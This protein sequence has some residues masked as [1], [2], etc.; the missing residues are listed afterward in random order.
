MDED[1]PLPSSGLD[2]DYF[3][4]RRTWVDRLS[5]LLRRNVFR[6]PFKAAN[7]EVVPRILAADR[8]GLRGVI[9]MG[10]ASLCGFLKDRRYRNAYERPRVEGIEVAP[11]ERRL[12]V[13][14]LLFGDEWRSYYFAAV[15]LGGLGCRFYGEFCVVLRSERTRQ[16]S[17]FDRNSYDLL[18]PPLDA[19]QD[20][21]SVVRALR[22]L[23]DRDVIPMLTA[24]VVPELPEENRLTTPGQISDLIL[25]DEDFAEVHIKGPITVED[26][27]EVRKSPEESAVTADIL[28]RYR[29][30]EM[31]SPAELVW[32]NW[33]RR[34][35]ELLRE[36]GT[37][38]RVV[39][40]TG[41]GFRWR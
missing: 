37:K 21:P 3:D 23:W 30:G 12:R 18:S 33:R 19:L 22:G 2:P 38:T 39:A 4:E 29:A 32:A 31:P 40:T 10:A 28:E 25:R 34:T 26:V 36:N 27:E 20:R 13:D 14:R 17:V 1:A 11:S 9:N 35:E 15:S 24:K 5:A 41:R 6:N 7:A 8:P 16:A